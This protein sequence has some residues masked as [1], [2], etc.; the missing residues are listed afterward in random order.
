MEESKTNIKEFNHDNYDPEI[1]TA[2][3]LLTL[4]KQ[5]ELIT[6][7]EL[8][9]PLIL[10]L[11]IE[12]KE[13]LQRVKMLSLYKLGLDVF[14]NTTHLG[15]FKRDKLITEMHK[16]DG[17]NPEDIINEFNAIMCVILDEHKNIDKLPVYRHTYTI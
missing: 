14:I 15:H 11:K 16:Y 7:A 3:G 17:K 8:K 4:K 9:N 13:L 5:L 12:Y 2:D 1:Y 6:E 10:T